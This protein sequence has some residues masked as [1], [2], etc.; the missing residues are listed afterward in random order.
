MQFCSNTLEHL[1]EL[2]RTIHSRRL[3]RLEGAKECQPRKKMST[4]SLFGPTLNENIIATKE[5]I[6]TSYFQWVSCKD[7]RPVSHLISLIGPSTSQI[8]FLESSNNLYADSSSVRC[9][10]GLLLESLSHRENTGREAL[11]KGLSEGR[12]QIGTIR[13]PKGDE[14]DSEAL[15]VTPISTSLPSSRRAHFSIRNCRASVISLQW[16]CRTGRSVVPWSQA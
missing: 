3:V 5:K 8:I 13:G 4:I 7:T 12:L 14:L 11:N 1:P 6:N 10:V 16:R 15:I 2:K 9:P